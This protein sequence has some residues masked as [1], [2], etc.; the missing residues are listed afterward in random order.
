M[1]SEL[2][3]HL[4]I[5]Y[6]TKEAKRAEYDLFMYIWLLGAH[7]TAWLG[8]QQGILKFNIILSSKKHL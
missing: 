4:F 2:H 8:R 5:I 7:R 3:V 6:Y 1:K